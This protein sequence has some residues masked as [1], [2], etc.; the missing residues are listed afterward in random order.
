M[1]GVNQ[2][3]AVNIRELHVTG[4][5]HRGSGPRN[6]GWVTANSWLLDEEIGVWNHE[7]AVG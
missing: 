5:G 1:V 2:V 3:C 6:R 7:I 4:R